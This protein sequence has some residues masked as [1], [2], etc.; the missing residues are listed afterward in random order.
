MVELP[1]SPNPL[2]VERRQ[3]GHDYLASLRAHGL[4]PDGLA[5]ALGANGDFYLLMVTS[6]VDRVGPRTVYDTLFK[7]YDHA[8]TPSTIDPWIVTVFSPKSE[9]GRAYLSMIDVKVEF[10]DDQGDIIDDVIHAHVELGAFR[11]RTDWIYVK[12]GQKASIA[13]QLRGWD[14]FKRDVERIA[15]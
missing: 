6:L 10:K 15:A 3:A 4:H 11:I 14:R 7:A 2:T 9:F 13:A 5:W 1:L 12:S 8:V